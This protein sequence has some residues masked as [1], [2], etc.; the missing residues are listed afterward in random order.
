MTF[1][2]LRDDLAISSD[3]TADAPVAEGKGRA[4]LRGADYDTAAAALAPDSSAAPAGDVVQ[5]GAVAPEATTASE[6]AEI[7]VPPLGDLGS[8]PMAGCA[9]FQDALLGVRLLRYGCADREA[10]TILQ[11]VLGVLGFA[12]GPPDGLW[13]PL[14]NGA[15]VAF[16]SANGLV[17]DGIIGPQTATGLGEA[18]GSGPGSRTPGEVDDPRLLYN[19]YVDPTT[20]EIVDPDAKMMG[21]RDGDHLPFASDL[22]SWDAPEILRRWSQVDQSPD[23]VTDADRCAVHAAMAPRIMAG[24]AAL[25]AYAEAI[26]LQGTWNMATRVAHYQGPPDPDAPYA[27]SPQDYLDALELLTVAIFNLRVS[28]FATYADLNRVAN[29]GLFVMA[30][31]IRNGASESEAQAIGELA[32][33]SSWGSGRDV[34]GQHQANASATFTSR[35]DVMNWMRALTPGEA[36]MVAVDTRLR[37]ENDVTYAGDT[38]HYITLGADGQGRWYLYDPNPT[39]GSQIEFFSEGDSRNDLFLW[40][41][42]EVQVTGAWNQAYEAPFKACGVVSAA[43]PASGSGGGGTPGWGWVE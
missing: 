42:F 10:V 1:E 5:D 19:D 11:T 13:G 32:G 33:G 37:D 6:E 40:P 27:V 30:E 36:Y 4:H 28:A 20:G 8:S 3:P 2:R 15:L 22:E 17:A 41:H 18:Y 29:A 21:E 31:D 25:I 35:A 16:Q 14:T 26:H 38:N 39:F 34:G 7:A 43:K 12:S 23:T 24:P 9:A